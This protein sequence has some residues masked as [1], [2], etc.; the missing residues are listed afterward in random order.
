MFSW[1]SFVLAGT[2]EMFIGL[3]RWGIDVE[4]EEATQEGGQYIQF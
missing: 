1:V 2:V 3:T 4:V